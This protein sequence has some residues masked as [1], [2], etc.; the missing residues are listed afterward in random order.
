MSL[1]NE[2]EIKTFFRHPEVERIYHTL[3]VLKESPLHKSKMVRDGNL[4][5]M[6][7]WRLTKQ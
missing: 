1:N 4:A 6:N 5:F 3:R 2:G 7:E